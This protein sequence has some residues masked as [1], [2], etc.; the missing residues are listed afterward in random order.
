MSFDL[1]TLE[2]FVRAATLGAIGRAGAEFDFSPTNASQRIKALEAELGVKLM[3]RTT[4]SVS[5]TPDG[6]VLL[7]NAKRILD[8]LEDVRTVLTQS[9]D[10]VSGALRVT[11]SASFG[12]AHIIPFIPEFVALYPNVSL[13]L[14]LSDTV[15]DIVEKGFDLAFRI[16]P[17]A[18]S[19]LLAQK[20][21]ANPVWLVASPE[22]I[23][24]AGHPQTPQDLSHH[25]CMPL[26]KTQNWRLVGADGVEHDVPV[27]G[28][29]SVNFGD[30]VGEWVVAG[31]GIGRPALWHAGPDLLAG[32]L[33][34]VLPDYDVV[35]QSN[36]WAVRPPGRL[37]PA[38]V[39]AFLSF[40]QDKIVATNKARYGGLLP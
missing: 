39:R 22:Y 36:I 11:A 15:V 27:S 37:M 6:E 18:P 12:R 2:L 5:L 38:R 16:G 4:R 17:L 23:E 10:A 21:D 35:P 19:S 3:N 34:R 26:G 20:I 14:D 33:V 13:E 25:A 31:M 8:E 24:K 9:K 40:M 32:R 28:P 29:V 1:K 7:E 30:A